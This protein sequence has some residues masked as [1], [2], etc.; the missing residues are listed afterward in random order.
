MASV[1]NI[2]FSTSVTMKRPVRPVPALEKQM[3]ETNNSDYGWLLCAIKLSINESILAASLDGKYG[4][5]NHLKTMIYH[6]LNG[7]RIWREA[8]QDRHWL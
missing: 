1:G 3:V 2:L 6:D 7:S 8:R 4:S 5:R